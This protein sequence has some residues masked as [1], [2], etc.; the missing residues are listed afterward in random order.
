[1]SI[2]G[3][4]LDMEECAAFRRLDDAL[5]ERAARRWLTHK[6]RDWC[7]KQDSLADAVLVV[8][9]CKE[10]VFKAWNQ[11]RAAHQV[12]LALTGSC[13]EGQGWAEQSPV[14]ITV[15]WRRWREQVVVLAVV[16]AGGLEFSS[17]NQPIVVTE[18]A[19][20]WP[21]LYSTAWR[22]ADCHAGNGRGPD[23]DVRADEGT[24]PV[25]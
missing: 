13:A 25:A 15:G 7:A 24:A 2:R 22:M 19:P 8:L 1:L 10:A 18:C 12:R 5:V 9:S 14:A 16:T 20:P 17:T 23:L 6:E 21:E 3:I 4:G 11:D